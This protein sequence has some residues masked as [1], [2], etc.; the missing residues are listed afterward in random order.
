MYVLIWCVF[1]TSGPSLDVL[2]QR[3]ALS[4]TLGFGFRERSD[5]IGCHPATRQ[6][7]IGHIE[8]WGKMQMGMT[9]PMFWLSG[10]AG[11]GKSAIMQSVA[12]RCEGHGAPYAIFC[13][14]RGDPARNNTSP[15]VATLLWQITTSYPS[16][17]G[18]VSRLLLTDPSILDSPLENQ[19]TQLIVAPLRDLQQQ[20]SSVYQPP[21]LLIDGIDECA[22]D[23]QYGPQ[24]I[25]DAFDKALVGHPHL[26]RLLVAS[27]EELRI[28]AALSEISS[29]CLHLQLDNSTDNGIRDFVRDKFQEIQTVHHLAHMLPANWPSDQDVDYIVEKASGQFLYA[30]CVMRFLLNSSE[31]PALSLERVR[32]S[33]VGLGVQHLPFLALDAMCFYILSQVDDQEALKDILH[34]HFLLKKLQALN[35]LSPEGFSTRRIRL[36]EVLGMYNPKYT[37]VMILSCLANLTSILQYVPN[38]HSLQFYHASF[39]DFLHDQARSREYFVDLAAFSYKIIPAIWK[40]AEIRI[41]DKHCKR[42]LALTILII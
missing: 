4:A 24:Q 11:A 28:Q 25:L 39:P 21:M 36:M 32:G 40:H 42:V 6:D 3:V 33:T 31:S 14:L 13:F 12:N 27:R 9:A 2:Y 18:P 17:K 37:E 5:G 10:P 34:A 26:F 16:L 22:P 1:M 20:R 30:S 7:V 19:L 38:D 8:N 29:Q 35:V 41:F 23:S 15:L